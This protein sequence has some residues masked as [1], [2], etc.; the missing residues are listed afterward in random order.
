MYMY[1]ELASC[2]LREKDRRVEGV[3]GVGGGGGVE[4]KYMYTELASCRLREKDRRVE[5]G[6]RGWRMQYT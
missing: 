6:W 3:G 1:T 4:C 2:R 5:G